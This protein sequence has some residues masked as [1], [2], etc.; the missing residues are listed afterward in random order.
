MICPPGRADGYVV[1]LAQLGDLADFLALAQLTGPGFTSL[2]ADALL[3]ARLLEN[4]HRAANGDEGAVFL[5][6][7]HVASGQV[8]GCA[9][10][11]RGGTKRAGFANFRHTQA[12]ENGCGELR[13]VDDY[14]ELTEIGGLFLHP[15]HRGGGLGALLASSRYLYLDTARHSFG[16]RVYAELRGAIAPDGTSPFYDA[17]CKPLLG[18]SFLEAD[19]IC[20][21]GDNQRLVDLFPSEPIN[22]AHFSPVAQLSIGGCHSAGQAARALLINEGF[23]FDGVVDLLD[24]GALLV[25][26]VTEL[27][28]LDNARTVTVQRSAAS[29]GPARLLLSAGS[30]TTFRCISAAVDA[31]E[32]RVFVSD[33]ACD[34][35]RMSDGNMVRIAPFSPRGTPKAVRANSRTPKDQEIGDEPANC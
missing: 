11:K 20:A 6:L 18:I 12:T 8:V 21:T 1:R 13:I 25:A 28:I 3:I 2:P 27:S 4:S 7:E 22:T 31:D 24:G 34:R 29:R 32:H 26:K 19:E 10:V 16:E 14:A 35:L 30:P 17:V 15:D 23:R 5:C 33:E 9:A